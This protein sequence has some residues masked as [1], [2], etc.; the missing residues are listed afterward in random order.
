MKV[1]IRVRLDADNNGTWIGEIVNA[2]L[3][4]VKEFIASLDRQEVETEASEY[5]KVLAAPI[6]R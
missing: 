6:V 3:V 1:F 4:E 5:A 2:S